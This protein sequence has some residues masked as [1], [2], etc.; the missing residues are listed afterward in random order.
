MGRR[1]KTDYTMLRSIGRQLETFADDNILE[2]KRCSEYQWNVYNHDKSI[3]L[4]IY[5]GSGVLYGPRIA[6]D[7]TGII[8]Q[9]GTK[10]HFGD[11][12]EL[13]KLLIDILFAVD[14]L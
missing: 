1:S 8:D 3:I 12:N 5:P 9:S 14:R 13:K 6:Y 2:W 7:N 11:W 10:Y 4:A